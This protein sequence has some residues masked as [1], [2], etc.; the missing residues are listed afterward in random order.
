MQAESRLVV[1]AIVEV[2]GRVADAS[3]SRRS[4]AV[5]AAD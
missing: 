4:A 2:A 3:P 1:D 5:A